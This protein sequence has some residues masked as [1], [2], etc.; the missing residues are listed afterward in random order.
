MP[1]GSWVGKEHGVTF[2]LSP[3]ANSAANDVIDRAAEAEKQSITPQVRSVIEGTDHSAPVGLDKSLKSEFSLKRKLAAE[4]Q[5]N[6]GWTADDVL[7]H[8]KD[9]V[10]YTMATPPE[11]YAGA[12]RHAV[13]NL[14]ARGFENVK[15]PDH[16]KAWGDPGGYKGLNTAWRDPTTG[17]V[18]ELQF[19][20]PQSFD[21]KEAAHR[22]YEMKRVLDPKSDADEV[23]RLNAEAEE[24]FSRVEVPANV[25]SIQHD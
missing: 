6:P 22:I 5:E 2:K 24:I 11:H 18:F 23:A 16:Q 20:T 9:T 21:A 17:Q 14:E 3:G 13:Q 12:V 4:L 1:D 25:E 15:F 19:H 10:R 8:M 7:G